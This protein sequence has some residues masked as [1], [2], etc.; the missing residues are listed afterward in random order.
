VSAAPKPV[1]QYL[2]QMYVKW[3]RADQQR[4]GTTSKNRMETSLIDYLGGRERWVRWRTSVISNI[5]V[6]RYRQTLL[7]NLQ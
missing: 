4:N 3:T 7:T 1:R 6:A 2:M 5:G